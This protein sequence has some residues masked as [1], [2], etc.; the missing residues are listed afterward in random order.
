MQQGSVTA[1]EYSPAIIYLHF[2]EKMIVQGE[3][4]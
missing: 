2:N 1:N 3:T 4:E